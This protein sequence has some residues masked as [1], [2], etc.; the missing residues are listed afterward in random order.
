MTDTNTNPA[1]QP[2]DTTLIDAA[3]AVAETIADPNPVNILKDLE[4]AAR[5]AQK[6]KASLSGLH[7][8]IIDVIKGML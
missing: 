2:E 5:L 8:S 7:P 1:P 3:E 4:V 6:F